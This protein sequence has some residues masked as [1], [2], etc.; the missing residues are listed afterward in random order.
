MCI[1]WLYYNIFYKCN[2]KVRYRYVS[3]KPSLKKVLK[4]IILVTSVLVQRKHS[5]KNAQWVKTQS[6]KNTR[7]LY[8]SLIMTSSSKKKNYV[9]CCRVVQWIKLSHIC[10]MM[11]VSLGNRLQN[12]QIITFGITKVHKPDWMVKMAHTLWSY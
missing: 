3:I 10:I 4:M 1:C 12:I 6:L 7:G 5:M 11:S 8:G 2:N 9:K